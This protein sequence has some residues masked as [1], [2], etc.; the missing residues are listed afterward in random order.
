M[1]E[2]LELSYEIES[3]KLEPKRKEPTEEKKTSG[4]K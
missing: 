3:A 2:C 4:K 1:L